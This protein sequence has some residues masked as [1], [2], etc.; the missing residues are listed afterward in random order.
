[1]TANTQSN[2]Q[3]VLAASISYTIWGLF[4]LYWKLFGNAP[5]LELIAHRI[6]WAFLFLLIVLLARRELGQLVGSLQSA[7]NVGWNLL[8]AALLTGNWLTFIWAVNSGHVIEC[9]L[10]YFLVPLINVLLGRF[11]LGERLRHLQL[12]AVLLA[13]AGVALMVWQVGD[14]PWIA[15]SIATTFGLYG[16]MRKRAVAGPLLG[17]ALETLLLAPLA[18]AFLLWRWQSGT[19]SFN[20]PTAAPWWLFV[21]TGCVTAIPL[22]LFAQGARGLR[23][24]TLGLLQYLAPTIQ[25]LVGW[26]LYH[27]KF[28]SERASAFVLIWSGLVIYTA[29]AYLNQRRTAPAAVTQMLSKT[30]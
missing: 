24:T 17:L 28:T 11:V 26:L 2:W 10:G 23:L 21:S 13:A 27:E 14:V 16:L 29:D 5:A 12:G 20:S 9:S 1:M 8:S 18:I 30:A 22:L 19:S 25:F 15:F 6:V 7:S 4:P 3:N